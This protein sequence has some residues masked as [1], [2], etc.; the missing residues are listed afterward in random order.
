M[1]NLEFLLNIFNNN[2]GAWL[3]VGLFTGMVIIA[4]VLNV[5]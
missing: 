3:T 4:V 5:I 2:L 1:K